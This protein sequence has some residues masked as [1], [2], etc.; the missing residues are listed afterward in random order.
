MADVVFGAEDTVAVFA[1]EVV[2]EG[3]IIRTTSYRNKCPGNALLPGTTHF[4][5]SLRL[6]FILFLQLVSLLL[7]ES[8][9]PLASK[10]EYDA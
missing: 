9:L 4:R 5:A 1:E 10:D 8:W 7:L 6:H 3:A 2:D